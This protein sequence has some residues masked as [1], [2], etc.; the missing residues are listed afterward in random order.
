[1]TTAAASL[2]ITA[3]FVFQLFSSYS[4]LWQDFREK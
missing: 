3:T 2:S 4:S 1:M